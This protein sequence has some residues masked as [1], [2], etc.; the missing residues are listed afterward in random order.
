[1]RALERKEVSYQRFSTRRALRESLEHSER[2]IKRFVNR[3]LVRL[4]QYCSVWDNARLSCGS[5]R[6]ASNSVLIELQAE[7]LSQAPVQLLFQEQSGWLVASI[8][9]HGWLD[10]VS[11]EM[12]HSFETALRG[13]YVKAGI[14]LVREQMERNL[15][16][17]HPYD[18]CGAG[19]AIWP[20]RQLDREITVDLHRR[21]QI[22][23]TPASMAAS[24]GLVPVSREAVVFSEL[25]FRWVDWK[26]VW[27]VPEDSESANPL[28][29]ACMQSARAS[30]LS[31][32]KS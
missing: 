26:R 23:P 9:Q 25:G 12:Q 4:L 7:S 30:L 15:V 3:D 19:L 20:D 22:R 13:F 24:Y 32:G 21:H 27:A 11:P 29:L 8:A 31:S 1:M 14:E 16:G 5:V 2:D 10:T 28:P 18:V 6:A 17:Q